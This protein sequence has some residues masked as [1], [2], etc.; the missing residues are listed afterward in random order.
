MKKPR[1]IS[2][3]EPA[4]EPIWEQTWLRVKGQVYMS[5]LYSMTTH[6]SERVWDGVTT[7]IVDRIQEQLARQPSAVYY[8]P[9]RL[10]P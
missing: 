2:V 7:P 10:E 1:L 3:R 8:P 5:A 4:W 9:R 6:L